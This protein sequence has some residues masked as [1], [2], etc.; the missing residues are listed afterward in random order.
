MIYMF[1]SFIDGG[2]AQPLPLAG[3]CRPYA[4][5][6]GRAIDAAADY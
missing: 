6:A 1:S 5:V 2:G 4:T 3:H